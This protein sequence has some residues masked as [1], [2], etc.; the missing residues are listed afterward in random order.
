MMGMSVITKRTA[1]PLGH[2]LLVKIDITHKNIRCF[3]EKLL[4]YKIVT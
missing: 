1:A 3:K 4:F 2:L